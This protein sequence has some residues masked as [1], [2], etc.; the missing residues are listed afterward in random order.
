MS[1]DVTKF[2][3]VAYIASF[4]GTVLG[5]TDG[6]PNIK[7]EP[8]YYESKCDQAGDQVLRKILIGYKVVVGMSL[9]EIDAGMALLM[10]ADS[11]LTLSDIGGDLLAGK[12]EL[13]LTPVG[14]ADS[15]SYK[16]P[17]AT[18]LPE[19]DYN[20]AGTEEHKLPVSFECYPDA[21]GVIMELVGA[22]SGE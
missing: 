15:N 8:V 9:K 12:G 7:I 14:V 20:L 5:G 3:L 18:L 16:F 22:A 1:F 6:P 17:G 19:T 10:G 4:K 21:D 11:K 2:K 13:I